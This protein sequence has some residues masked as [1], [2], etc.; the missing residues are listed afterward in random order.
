M[1]TKYRDDNLSSTWTVEPTANHFMPKTLDARRAAIQ[2]LLKFDCCKKTLKTKDDGWLAGG[3]SWRSLWS[4][5]KL[6][7][8]SAD[9]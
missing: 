1:H 5:V 7:G 9:E 3:S 6:I 8:R 2:A 4:P